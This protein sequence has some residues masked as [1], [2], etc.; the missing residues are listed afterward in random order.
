MAK[1]VRKRG[2][3][4]SMLRVF[5]KNSSTGAPLTTLT[6]ASVNLQISVIRELSAAPTIY[7][8]ANIETIATIGT[9]AAPTTSA[10]CRFKAVDTTNMPGV[11]ELQFHDDAGH[12]GSGDA[13]KNLQIHIFEIT[14]T[15]LNIEHNLSEFQ[16]VAYDPQD[17]VRL[18]LT[19]LPNAAADAAG[20]L[21]I[22]DAGGLDM[23]SIRAFIIGL[24]S[25]PKNTEFA[26]FTF[27][28]VD[29]NGA[30]ATGL[31]V[32][33]QR[34]IDGAAFAACA[35]PVSEV[36][37]GTYKI[38]L[39]AADLNGDVVMLKFTATAARQVNYT[40]ITEATT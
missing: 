17:A 7:T 22:S 39:A 29:A 4:S 6:S 38:T 34:S 9:F 35:N 2:Q 18:G 20:G 19:A 16:L 8:G 14:T 21:P 13:S 23:D 31:T 24:R 37:S 28:M 30:A 10:K 12:F 5:I 27:P 1:L 36:G 25:F 32:T 26:N 3:T 40:I 11:Y 15:A 33:A